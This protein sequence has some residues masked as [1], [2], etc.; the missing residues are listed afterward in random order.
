[1]LVNG[2]LEK[3]ICD[4]CGKT[5]KSKFLAIMCE[6]THKKSLIQ[7]YGTI[8]HKIKGETMKK[9]EEVL[10]SEEPE[11]MKT[12]EQ[13]SNNLTEDSIKETAARLLDVQKEINGEY[14]L[15]VAIVTNDLEVITKINNFCFEGINPEKSR[16]L[17][18]NVVSIG[19]ATNG[20]EISNNKLQVV[21]IEYNHSSLAQDFFEIINKSLEDKKLRLIFRD[22]R[23]RFGVNETKNKQQKREY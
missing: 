15:R 21:A 14:L 7:K 19:V 4:F 16:L 13:V 12:I 1:M 17:I 6:M 20:E 10:S 22:I 18:N 2:D 5:H 23:D 3:S 11:V 9:D 8:D